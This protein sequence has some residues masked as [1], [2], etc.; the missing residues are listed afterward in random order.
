MISNFAALSPADYT[1]RSGAL[2][3]ARLLPQAL[4]LCPPSSP[5]VPASQEWWGIT[6]EIKEQAL[7]IAS[8]GF[9]VL[10]SVRGA[11]LV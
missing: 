10:V 1:G 7:K 2:D 3:L 11:V 8:K 6:D 4:S 5:S 9:R